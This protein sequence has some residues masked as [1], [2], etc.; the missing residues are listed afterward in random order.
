MSGSQDT[1]GFRKK[2][3]SERVSFSCAVLLKKNPAKRRKI[4]R[5]AFMT[6]LLCA[7][8]AGLFMASPVLAE[9]Y[10]TRPI[11]MLTMVKPGAQID[12]LT[13]ALANAM[14]AELG[15][16][17]LVS[18]MPG[19]SHGSVMASEISSA[20]P[21]GYTLGVGA[22]AAYTYSPH[23]VKTHYKFDDF[24]FISMLGLNQS[25]FVSAPD[26]P[27][28]TL[29]DAFEWAR[30]ENKGLTYMFQGS[31]DRD[32]MKRIA[33][34]EGVKLAL[35]PSTGGPSIISAVM[36]GH[37][38]IGHLGA[39]LFEYVKG[40][41]LKLLAASTPERLT[42]IPDVPTL[43]EQGWDESVEMFVVIVAPKGL[44]DA[45]MARLDKVMEKLAKDEKF[46]K[47]ISEDLKMRPVPFGR[48]HADA[49]MKHAYERFGRE[50]AGMNKN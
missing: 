1:K 24:T 22:T 32:A 42:Q 21:D 2:D 20:K 25:G 46:R 28:K 11:K 38:D 40:G 15:Q 29:K 17:I 33:A 44:P 26:R 5:S 16:P 10:P 48:D 6:L 4:M 9:D 30:K 49:Y 19:G 8:I 45:V 13:R 14:G 35:M 43:R 31:D 27:W 47:F 12:L 41:K 36:G 23:F 3:A 18:N 7:V 37:A 50:A 34:R 39:I